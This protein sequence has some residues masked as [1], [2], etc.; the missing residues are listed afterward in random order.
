MRLLLFVPRVP[1]RFT[2][3]YDPMPLRG[4]KITW[5]L[6]GVTQNLTDPPRGLIRGKKYC[7]SKLY[8]SQYL[9]HAICHSTRVLAILDTLEGATNL[10]GTENGAAKRRQ[11]YS[12]GWSRQAEP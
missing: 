7:V 1:L 8:Q 4:F 6:E 11:D 3:G 9:E 12:L 5:A 10:F 2:L